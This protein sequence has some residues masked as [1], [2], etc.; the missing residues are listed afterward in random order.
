MLLVVALGLELFSLGIA[1]AVT[2]MDSGVSKGRAV[3]TITCLAALI[4]I[5]AIAG[6]TVLR[7][8]PDQAMEAILSFGLAAL[9]FLVTEELLV[10]AHEVPETPRI[11]ACFFA[12]FL[13]LLIVGMVT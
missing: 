10:E 13:S 3:F 9:L 2:L 7:N 6:T 4:L 12:G 1:T 11:T 8:A 5:G